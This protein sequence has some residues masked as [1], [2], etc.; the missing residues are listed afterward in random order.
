MRAAEPEGD[1]HLSRYENDGRWLV[2]G[3][4]SIE[5]GRGAE[6]GIGGEEEEEEGVPGGVG[7]GIHADQLEVA[8][9]RPHLDI[10]GRIPERH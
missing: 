3:R 5:A 9:I 4:R 10:V 6:Q 2:S 7:D 8:L 1:T